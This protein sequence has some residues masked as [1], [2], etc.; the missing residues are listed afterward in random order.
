MIEIESSRLKNEDEPTRA[1]NLDD[2]AEE[3]YYVDD[4]WTESLKGTAKGWSIY[5]RDQRNYGNC[6]PLI[7]HDG[8]P[9]I[10]VGPDCRN[11]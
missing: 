7:F 10:I 3:E 8:E 9:L 5:S 6:L 11:S 2:S 1:T 4:G